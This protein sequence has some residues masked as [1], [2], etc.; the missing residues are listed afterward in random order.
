MGE[1]YSANKS[2]RTFYKY[3]EMLTSN[4]KKTFNDQ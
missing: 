1:A 2:E 3:C 4:A